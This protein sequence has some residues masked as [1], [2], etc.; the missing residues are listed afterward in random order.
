MRPVAA[1]VI[2]LAALLAAQ[3]RGGLIRRL[4]AENLA[5]PPEQ[6]VA[7]RYEFDPDV[8]ARRRAEFEELHG[9]RGERLV[10]RLGLG[11]DG[12]SRERRLRQRAR[13]L[14]PPAAATLAPPANAT[15]ATPAA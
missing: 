5:G 14:A 8:A 10:E 4:I 3:A 6:R 12:F 2:A 13:D 7:A 9:P 1:C 11:E 15:L